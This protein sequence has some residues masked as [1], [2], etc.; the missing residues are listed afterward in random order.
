MEF[1]WAFSAGVGGYVS[2]YRWVADSVDIHVEVF[3]IKR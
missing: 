1:V 3:A 2:D